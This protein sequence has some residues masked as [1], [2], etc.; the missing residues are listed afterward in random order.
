MFTTLLD[1]GI[2]VCLVSL[3]ALTGVQLTGYMWYLAAPTRARTYLDMYT[4]MRVQRPVGRVLARGQG[5]I[6]VLDRPWMS[7]RVKYTEHGVLIRDYAFHNLCCWSTLAAALRGQSPWMF[8]PW[9]K[10][11]RPRLPASRSM[12]I[13]QYITQRQWVQLDI[14]GMHPF[15][16]FLE[17]GRLDP[18]L[19]RPSPERT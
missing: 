16:L 5:G 4:Q 19:A 3:T 17:K 6:G 2:L 11:R 9:D 13:D 1:L 8:V 14:A 12:R 10:C 18:A 15:T 7:I